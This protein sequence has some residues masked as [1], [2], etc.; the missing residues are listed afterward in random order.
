MISRQLR[1]VQTPARTFVSAPKAKATTSAASRSAATSRASP[2]AA[3]KS[4]SVSKPAPPTSPPADAPASHTPVPQV[5]DQPLPDVPA[6]AQTDNSG[7]PID[8]SSSFHGLGTATFGPEVATVL[9][10][11]LDEDDIEVKPDG[12]IYLPEIKYRRVLNAAFG[13]GG[14]G[15]APRG[16]LQVQD[17][18]VYRDYALI[19]HGR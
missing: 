2:A 4:A 10:A 1:I 3:A 8:W 15:L 17:R 18:L 6:S 7:S 14:W 5:S 13:P 16:D 12:I 9:Q 19:A 11:P